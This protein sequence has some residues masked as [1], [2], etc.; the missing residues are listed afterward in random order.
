LTL[1]KRAEGEDRVISDVA[2][3]VKVLVVATNE[4]I[5]IARDT[6]EISAQS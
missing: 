1:K 5:M 3:R 2:S 6:A 4:E